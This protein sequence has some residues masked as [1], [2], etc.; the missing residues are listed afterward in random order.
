[1]ADELLTCPRFMF[2]A[3]VSLH[4]VLVTCPSPILL[5]L[6]GAEPPVRVAYTPVNYA[7]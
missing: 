6:G 7:A 5:P 1:M 4:R 2:R 3:Y